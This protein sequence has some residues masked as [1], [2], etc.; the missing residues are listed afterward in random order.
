MDGANIWT[1][2]SGST[3]GGFDPTAGRG[4]PTAVDLA[5][6]YEDVVYACVNL[7]SHAV[8]QEAAKFRLVAAT[9]PGDSAPKSPTKSFTPAESSRIAAAYPKSARRALRLDEVVGHGLLDLL[10]KPNHLQSFETLLRLTGVYLELIGSAFW[11]VAGPVVAG[12]KVPTELWLLPSHLVSVEPGEDGG[13]AK[14]KFRSGETEEVYRPEDV[15][16]LKY[17]PDPLSPY[18]GFGVSPAR[19]VWQ[20][21]QLLRSEQSSWEAVLANMAFPSLVASPPDGETFTTLQAQR[22]EKQLSEKFRWGNQGG[23]FVVQDSTKY[24]PL[25]VPPKDLSALTM[26]DQIKASVARAYG[27]PLPILDLTDGTSEASDAARRNFQRYC[28]APRVQSLLDTISLHLAP[29]RTFL[30]ATSVV[31]PDKV[32]ELQRTTAL[33]SGNVITVNEAR[34]RE[35]YDARPG[36][37]R[38]LCEMTNT[39]TASAQTFQASFTGGRHKSART[40]SYRSTTPDPKPLAEALAGVFSKLGQAVLGKM[41]GKQITEVRTKS[42]VPMADWTK[43]MGE[44]LTPVLRAYF[45]EGMNAVLAEVGGGPDIT[46]HVVHELEQAVSGAVL[47]LAKSTLDTTNLSVEEAVAATREA[48]RQGLDAGEAN[49]QLAGRLKDI[50]TDLSDRRV[51]LIA[52]TESNRA[53]HAGELIAIEAS[54]IEA[55]KRWLPDSMACDECRGLAAKGAIGLNTAFVVK[56]SGPYARVDHPPGHPGCRCSLQYDLD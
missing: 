9:G 21:I 16:H 42:F 5:N 17:N 25:T 51:M 8:A 47:A 22:L 6:A 41:S 15:I 38:L 45:D 33:V 39:G 35:G 43:E 34:E 53:K 50:F 24:T 19:A 37:D 48:V 26:Y 10:D 28:V 3:F 49:R 56:G 52:E 23:V 14:Y 54:G 12:R 1:P 40:K 46:R 7:V 4:L 55:K 36:L 27:V 2:I 20:R 18:T 31:S 13:P 44:A 32:F 30:A 11:F 29:P